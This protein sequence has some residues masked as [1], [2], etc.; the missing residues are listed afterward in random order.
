LIPLAEAEGLAV[1]PYQVFEGGLLTGK[2]SSVSA[3]EGLPAVS[4]VLL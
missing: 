4:L 3:G 1:C 2:Y